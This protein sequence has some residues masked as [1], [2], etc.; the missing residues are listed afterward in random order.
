MTLRDELEQQ[1]AKF[2]Q[3]AS[4]ELAATLQAGVD[5]LSASGIAERAVQ[6]GDMAPDFEL[7]NVKGN[8]VALSTLLANGPVV[9]A[10]YRGGWCPYCNLQ[11]R[12]YQRILPQIRELG[13]QLLA[14]SP[15]APDASLTTA[16]KN[17]LE[18]EVLSDVEGKAAQAYR[19]LFDL[20]DAL[21]ETYIGMGRDLSA[22]N[23][24]GQWHLPIPATYIIG[25]D[26]RVELAYI[27]PEYRTRL[28]PAD[29]LDALKRIRLAEAQLR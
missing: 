24:D 1:L 8:P 6:Q 29:I 26:G 2:K 27:D 25:Q 21:K 28:E 13:A 7:P 19:I 18:F 20:S 5:E 11:L 9:L 17:A 4:A 12:A 14:V 22:D 16:E 23:A 15:Q 3:R 10:F